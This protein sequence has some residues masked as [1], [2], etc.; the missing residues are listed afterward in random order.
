MFTT[1]TEF[2][3]SYI[4]YIIP[5]VYLTIK[6]SIISTIISCF[7]G[8]PLG[9]LIGTHQFKFKKLVWVLLNT[10]CGFP[11]IVI[12]LFV[13]ILLSKEGILGRLE[14]L[15][16]IYAIITAQVILSLPVVMLLSAAA[17][18]AI[19][20]EMADQLKGL[21]AS[22]P[23]IMKYILLEAKEGI[24]IAILS[25]FGTAISELGAVLLVGGN[26]ENHTRVLSTAIFLE[27]R[28]GNINLALIL[29]IILICITLII[30]FI[31]LTLN[32][33]QGEIKI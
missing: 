8:L 28:K 25:G 14:W 7:I 18:S 27:T 23:F 29:G 5:I 15:F 10:G 17:T 20:S 2:F 11:P 24:L 4:T 33:K 9:V 21:G 22:K 3:K 12:G 19:T 1:M 26:I 13:Y 6:V 31:I 32:Y 16:T 30:N